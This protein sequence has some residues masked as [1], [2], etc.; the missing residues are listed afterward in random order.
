[1]ATPP[2]ADVISNLEHDWLS[3]LHNKAEAIK[4]YETYISDAE[5]AGSQPCVDLFRKIRDT[6]IEQVREIREHLMAVMQHGKM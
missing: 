1:M 4:A 6:E 2:T 3:T 5:A